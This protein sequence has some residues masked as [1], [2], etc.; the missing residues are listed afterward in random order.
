[1]ATVEETAAVSARFECLKGLVTGGIV[2]LAAANHDASR[3]TPP[4]V[5]G[6]VM[7]AELFAFAVAA[8]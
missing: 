8:M 3:P 1:V 4:A 7:T 6:G 5:A 2:I